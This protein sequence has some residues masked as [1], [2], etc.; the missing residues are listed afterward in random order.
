[1]KENKGLNWVLFIALSVIWGSSFKLMKEGMMSLSAYQ[2]ASIRMTSAGI[3]LLP[4]AFKAI[5][6]I[7]ANKRGLIVL[8]GLLGSFFPAYLFCVAETKIDGSLAGILNALTPLFTILVAVT[9][10]KAKVPF[11]K[12]LGV[13]IGFLGLCLLFIAKGIPEL[14][15]VGYSSLVLIATVC[16]GL[17]VNLV[18]RH[19]NGIDSLHIASAAFCFLLIPSVLI[20]AAT[21]YF[22]LDFTDRGVITSTGSAFFLGAMGT[23][24][25]SI[26][27]Y[28]LVKRAGVIFSAMV[29][30]GI[31]FVAILWGLFDSEDITVLQMGCLG[32]ILAGVYVTNKK[33]KAKTAL[34]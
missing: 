27:F 9:I 2:V 12:W 14:S 23:A 19:L 11:R 25:A 26:I 32:I 16:Y 5:R 31:P 4:F 21:G 15:H 13:I 29:T 30:Y 6:T 8:S 24:V 17:N 7:P 1:M 34:Q 18:S 22:S 33:E 20:L 10:F 28:I 3:V